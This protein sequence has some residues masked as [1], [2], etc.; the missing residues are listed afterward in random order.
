VP[1]KLRE[2]QHTLGV[3]VEAER[4]LLQAK[5][6]RHFFYPE[7]DVTRVAVSLSAIISSRLFCYPEGDVTR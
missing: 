4:L 3:Q 7:G 2:L 1:T 6:Q 5:P